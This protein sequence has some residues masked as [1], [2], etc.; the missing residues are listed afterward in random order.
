MDQYIAGQD[1]R[2]VGLDVWLNRKRCQYHYLDI[3]YD[4]APSERCTLW[5]PYTDPW[6]NSTGISWLDQCGTPVQG[7]V[8]I[9]KESPVVIS[10]RSKSD[11]S[12]DDE[13]HDYEPGKLVELDI[14][15]TYEKDIG[16][17]TAIKHSIGKITFTT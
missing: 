1:I 10:L 6:D 4:R 7:Y 11:W 3:G 12:D 15:I 17:E 13:C 8:P 9:P 14:D 5:Q 16:E 2:V